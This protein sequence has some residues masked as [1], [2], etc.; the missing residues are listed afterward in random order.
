MTLRIRNITRNIFPKY[1]FPMF[2]AATEGIMAYLRI[3]TQ[4]VLSIIRKCLTRQ[5]SHIRRLI[6][7]G[8][9]CARPP[10]RSTTKPGS[11]ASWPTTTIRWA[12]GAL[13]TR[14]AAASSPRIRPRPALTSPAPGRAWSSM[15][16]SSR[17]SGAP[18]RLTSPRPLQAPPSSLGSALCTLRAT[19]S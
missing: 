8:T 7:P 10:R 3:R 1:R 5:T 17:T 12:T 19:G 6:G 4:L 11:T 15:W 18:T 16:A 9:I 14:P 2:R 13:S